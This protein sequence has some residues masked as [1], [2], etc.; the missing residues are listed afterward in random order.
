MSDASECIKDKVTEEDENKA[1]MTEFASPL[2]KN[3]MIFIVFILITKG[4][5]SS[6]FWLKIW[7]YSITVF[8]EL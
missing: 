3:S 1:K 4:F 7:K 2:G 6:K 5:F 8:Q